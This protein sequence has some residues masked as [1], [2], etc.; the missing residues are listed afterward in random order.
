LVI[1]VAV[2]DR[3]PWLHRPAESPGLADNPPT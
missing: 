3:L 2:S 1:A